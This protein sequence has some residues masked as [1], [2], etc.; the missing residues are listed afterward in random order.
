MED[1]GYVGN[2]D[3]TG[4]MYGETL[5]ESGQTGIRTTNGKGSWKDKDALVSLT[6]KP[7]N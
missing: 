4:F 7:A 1:W 5:T 3:E 6:I 2:D